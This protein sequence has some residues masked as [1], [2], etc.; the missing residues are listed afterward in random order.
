VYRIIESAKWLLYASRELASLLKHKDLV[1][2]LN[3]LMERSAKGVK[4]ELLPLVRLEGVGRA[5]ARILFNSGLKTIEDLKHA[6]IERLTQ[7][8]LVGPKVAKKIK[9]QVGGF[10]KSDQWKKLNNQET[11]EQQALTEYY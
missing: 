10:V 3:M 5:R 8:P 7:L 1:P 2:R 6:P 4:A 9:E 11:P